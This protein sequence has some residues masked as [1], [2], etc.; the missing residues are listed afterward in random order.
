MPALSPAA[1]MEFLAARHALLVHF[2]TAQSD[3]ATGYPQDLLGAR[4]VKGAPLSFS[5]LLAG[6]TGAGHSL[7]DSLVA[8]AGGNVGIVVR[9]D[10][11][12][13]VVS[14]DPTDSGSKAGLNGQ[15]QTGGL[16]PTLAECG[17]SLDARN[18]VNEW[19]VQDYT[20]LGMFVFLPADVFV[21]YSPTPGDCGEITVDLTRVLTD[22]PGER[23]FSTYPGKKR[24][25]EYDRVTERWN[26]IDYSEITL[27]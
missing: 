9:L 25:L 22:F 6:D 4:G 7:R 26:E 12:A 14:V 15:H 19:F 18:G 17:R 1:I 24:F 20:T 3:H 5:T 21:R 8:N 11:G 10:A 16:P 2:N 23:I 13:H 27:A